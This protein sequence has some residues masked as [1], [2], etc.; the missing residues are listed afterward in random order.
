M[1]R[2]LIAIFVAVTIGAC[3]RRQSTFARHP[4]IIPPGI[5]AATEE[6]DAL[7]NVVTNL[8]IHATQDQVRELL[9][10]PT[11]P[12]DS[13]W[14][15]HLQEDSHEGGYYVTATIH[16]ENRMLDEIDIGFGHETITPR[17]LE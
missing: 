6:Q 4:I 14:F 17:E 11:E 8:P 16:F 10:D 5:V 9:G 3:A 15:Y 13:S 2:A 12:S 1:R 7:L